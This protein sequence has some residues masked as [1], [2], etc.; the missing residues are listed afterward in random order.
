[1]FKS[2]VVLTFVYALSSIASSLFANDISTM[3]AIASILMT[4]C[5]TELALYFGAA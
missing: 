2:A 1:M 3:T 4:T 5:A